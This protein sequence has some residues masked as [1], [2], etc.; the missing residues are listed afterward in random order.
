[1]RIVTFNVQHA[2]SPAGTV[3]TTALARYCAGLGADVM[4]LQEVDHGLRRSGGADQASVVAEATGLTPFFGAARRVGLR[5]RY[6]NVLLVRG[7]LAEA[8]TLPLPR[9]GRGEARSAVVAAGSV[10]G[11]PLSLAATHLSVDREEAADQLEH[12]L[13]LLVSRPSPRVLLGDLNLRPDRA[14]PAL[15]RRGFTVAATAAPTYPAA[16]P[17]LR[18]DHVAVEGLEVE[19]VEVL[20]AAPVSDHRPLVVQVR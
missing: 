6:G 10:Y 5:G 3:D 4:A 18:I 11:R 17:F 1:M 16:G 15:E 20:E 8:A 13:D 14:L 7:Q 9:R 19:A 12:V 2:R